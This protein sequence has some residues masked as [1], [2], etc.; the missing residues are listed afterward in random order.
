MVTPAGTYD[1][2]TD[3]LGSVTGLLSSS[4]TQ[5]TSTTYSPYGMPTTT[6]SPDSSIGYAGSYSLPGGGGLDD[7]RSRDYSP[8]AGTFTSADPLLSVSGEPYAYADDDPVGA[9]DPSGAITCPGWIPG[10]GVITDVQHFVSGYYS[11]QWHDAWNWLNSDSCGGSAAVL[12]PYELASQLA[13]ATGGSIEATSSPGYGVLIP[14]GSKGIMVRVMEGGGGYYRIS[15]PGKETFTGS[16]EVSTERALTHM[17]IED[18]SLQDILEVIE[19]IMG[20]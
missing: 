7:M 10:C 18:S 11:T 19:M 16:G 6:G 3:W 17:P 8:S 9:T 1:A 13:E 15:I 12:T 5:V 20:G 4:G 2:V 14:Y